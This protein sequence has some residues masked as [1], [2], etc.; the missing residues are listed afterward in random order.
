[1]GI[2]YF[3]RMLQERNGY[4]LFNLFK[5]YTAFWKWLPVEYRRSTGK[6]LSLS[7]TY[8]CKVHEMPH[9]L[10]CTEISKLNHV[11][12]LNLTYLSVC[13]CITN[14][15]HPRGVWEPRH[16]HHTKYNIMGVVRFVGL[17]ILLT[18]AIQAG[19]SYNTATSRKTWWLFPFYKWVKLNHSF[20]SW[21]K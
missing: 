21:S 5:I 16:T 10:W 4:L 9:G 2:D 20:S 14:T 13:V 18:T 19:G 3:F 6:T 15:L 8:L 12:C 17:T 7:F 1:M 11:E